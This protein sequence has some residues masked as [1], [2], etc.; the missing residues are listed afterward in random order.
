[1]IFPKGD[2]GLQSSDITLNMPKNHQRLNSADSKNVLM[3][4]KGHTKGEFDYLKLHNLQKTVTG[5]I[6]Q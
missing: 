4:C 5:E 1:M 6:T 3:A 2:T